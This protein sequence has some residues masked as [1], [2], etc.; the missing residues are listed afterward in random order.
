MV[1][2]YFMNGTSSDSPNTRLL[3]E[4]PSITHSQPTSLII[5]A[6]KKGAV[7]VNASL[8]IY[9]EQKRKVYYYKF[10]LKLLICHLNIAKECIVIYNHQ[11]FMVDMSCRGDR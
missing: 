8:S 7:T 5:L 4:C 9:T 6:L 10:S 1:T 3:S 11:C 2:I